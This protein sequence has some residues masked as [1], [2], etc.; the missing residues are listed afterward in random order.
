MAT[1]VAAKFKMAAD[2]NLVFRILVG[3]FAYS[4]F[5]TWLRDHEFF[6]QNGPYIKNPR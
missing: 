4:I 1:N 3:F 2:Q 6:F 5:S